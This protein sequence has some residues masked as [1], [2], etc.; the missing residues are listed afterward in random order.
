MSILK[1]LPN[2]QRFHKTIG[3]HKKKYINFT[4]KIC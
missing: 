1:R 2:I 3:K 4:A